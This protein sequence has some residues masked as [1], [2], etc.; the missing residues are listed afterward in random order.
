MHARHKL[1]ETKRYLLSD[2]QRSGSAWKDKQESSQMWL[3]RNQSSGGDSDELQHLST[4]LPLK[5][6][7][8]HRD[9]GNL[10]AVSQQPLYCLRENLC[11][12]YQIPLVL[13]CYFHWNL[14]LQF[15]FHATK[16]FLFVQRQ[17]CTHLHLQMLQNC[18][19]NR[20]LSK[21]LHHASQKL[22]FS[23]IP[24]GR[25]SQGGRV[26]AFIEGKMRRYKHTFHVNKYI[27]FEFLEAIGSV[28]KDSPN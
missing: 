7:P 10:P 1:D 21:N 3:Y 11:R 26:G 28:Y 18:W 24:V 4:E 6:L 8:L 13:W 9:Y 19:L 15:G 5:M 17:F 27:I 25:Y 20:V 16:T 2:M 14:Q 23:K 12:L 22:D